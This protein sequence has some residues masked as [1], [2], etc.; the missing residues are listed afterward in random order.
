[1][2]KKGVIFFH[3]N[4]REIYSQKWIDLCVNSI[5]SQSVNDF[6]IYEV[7]YGG[8]NYSILDGF[9]HPQKKEFFC[10]EF[11]NHAEAM[12][13]IIDCA[14]SDGCDYVFNTN[15]DDYYSR[16]RIQKQLDA[17][18]TEVD[19]VTSNFYYITEIDN[20]DSIVKHLYVSQHQNFIEKE[21]IENSH[22]IIAHPVV[23]YSKKFWEQNRYDPSESPLEDLKLWQ[24]A[25]R[26][27]FK[28][29]IL[30]DFLL[31]YRLHENQV[32]GDNL[33]SDKKYHLNGNN[34]Q[35]VEIPSSDPTRLP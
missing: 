22:N 9:D 26:T 31:H 32:T 3:K 23:A 4:I 33:L 13:F 24:R 15:L 16:F 6:K 21:L 35:I 30:S 11:S 28:F 17:F 10:Q 18:S 29:K 2:M 14:F 19:I 8:T 5:I 25:Y 12:N 20:V 1:M 34:H 7:N 27:G